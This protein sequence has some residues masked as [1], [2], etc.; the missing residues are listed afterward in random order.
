MI[1]EESGGQ[2]HAHI[3]A[4]QLVLL[5]LARVLAVAMAIP[6]VGANYDS[7]ERCLR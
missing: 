2:G 6:A 7:G 5:S 4:T 3:S 1:D